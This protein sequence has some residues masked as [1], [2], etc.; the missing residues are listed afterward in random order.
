M[1]TPSKFLDAVHYRRSIYQLNNTSPISDAR[2][3]EIVNTIIQDVPSSFNSQSTRLLVLLHSEHFQFWNIVLE[4][5]KEIVPD[6]AFPKTEKRI[7]G[8]QN[9]Y[10]TI[11]FYEDTETVKDLQAKYELYA[12]RFPQWAEHASGMHQYALW[13]ALEAEGLGANIQHY[14]P[15]VDQQAEKTWNI[16]Q[17]WQLKAQ[18]VFGGCEG[19]ARESLPPKT[20]QPIEAR[21]FVHGLRSD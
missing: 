8:F 13:T 15:L 18:L 6:G 17:N 3:V 21:L 14:N 4:C 5:L 2:I 10:G 16:P 7:S 11:L 1:E 19:A 12:D 9:S 20:Q